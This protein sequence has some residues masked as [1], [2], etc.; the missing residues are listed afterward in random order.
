M[1]SMRGLFGDAVTYLEEEYARLDDDGDADDLA[2][3]I[4][5]NMV[6]VYDGELLE[7][8]LS[9]MPLATTVPDT[10]WFD[11]S[12][13]AV[14]A[15]A[16][17]VFER[18]REVLFDALADLRDDCLCDRCGEIYP[19]GLEWCDNEAVCFHCVVELNEAEDEEERRMATADAMEY[20]H[21]GAL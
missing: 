1:V 16:G 8:A 15:I 10:Y 21:H 7:L 6:P 18:L 4:A 2:E 20:R 14:N 11:G 3:E 17:N 19:P 12:H 5:D 9:D 13:T